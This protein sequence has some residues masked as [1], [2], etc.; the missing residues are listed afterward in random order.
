MFKRV[1][2]IT[3]VSVIALFASV[4][5]AD[6]H[7]TKPS[8]TAR[9][10]FTHHGLRICRTP[11]T[12][13]AKKAAAKKVAAK[14]AVAASKKSSH[15]VAAS[16]QTAQAQASTVQ[17]PVAST[18]PCGNT[19]LTPDAANIPLVEAATQCLVNQVRGEH[20]LRALTENSDLQQAADAHNADQVTRDYFSHTDPSGGTPLSRV[21]ATGYMNPNQAYLLG[22][23]IAW[24]TLNLST[25]AAIVNAW[26]NSPDH[27]ANILDP[28]YTQTGLAASTQAPPSLAQGQQGSIYT[29]DF[30]GIDNN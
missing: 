22:E 27:L 15:G 6:A 16:V 13:A 23:N 3:S 14:R 30:G 20:G 7:T 28:T 19:G 12:A 25:P 26:V 9:V 8:H 10:C 11:R 5:V 29:Q 18:A 1:L 2:H 17:A 24:G 21:Q 4:G